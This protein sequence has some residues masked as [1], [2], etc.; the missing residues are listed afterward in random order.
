MSETRRRATLGELAN[1]GAAALQAERY[2]EAESMLRITSSTTAQMLAQTLE[3]QGRYAEAIAGY[4]AALALNPA[5]SDT[6]LGLALALL[7]E[8]RYRQAWPLWES[9]PRPAG[10]PA[11]PFPEW[12]G[13]AI[14]SLL[15]LPEQG[16]GDQIMFARFVRGL[17]ARGIAV[18]IACLAPLERLYAHLGVNVVRVEA[19]SGTA[20]YDA[21]IDIGSLPSVLGA[22]S[23]SLPSGIFLPKH[24][25]NPAGSRRIGLVCAGSKTHPNDR[26]RSLPQTE[27]AKLLSAEGVQNAD[28]IACGHQDLEETRRLF[29]TLDLVITVDTATAHLA[30]AMGMPVW[31]LLPFVPDWRWSTEATRSAWHP[32]AR[33]FRQPRRGDW[34]SVIDAVLAELSAR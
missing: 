7:R 34:A 16:L 3:A 17:A 8:G 30:G 33:L 24:Q 29:E 4:E 28:P 31:V 11:F 18:T 23:D 12:K 32:S 20:M 9:R 27:A 22:E 21:W 26:N 10:K 13:Q 15:V 25:A 2:D 1:L 5:R 19:M 6:R 14:A